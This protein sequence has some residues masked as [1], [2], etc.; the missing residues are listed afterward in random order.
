PSFPGWRELDDAA[1]LYRVPATYERLMV[2]RPQTWLLSTGWQKAGS[3]SMSEVP[4]PR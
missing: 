3:I 2:A 1:F 4:G